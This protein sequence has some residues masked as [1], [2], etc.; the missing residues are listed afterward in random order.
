MLIVQTIILFNIYLFGRMYGR[1]IENTI[2]LLFNIFK[3]Y[4]IALATIAKETGN[5][6]L[7]IY[8]VILQYIW[9]FTAVKNSLKRKIM[10]NFFWTVEKLDENKYKLTHYINDE[11]IHIVIKPNKNYKNIIGIYDEFYN[12]C[13]TDEVK[14]YFLY[15]QSELCSKDINETEN[16]VVVYDKQNE[17]DDEYPTV[18]IPFLSKEVV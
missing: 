6:K 3:N 5:W 1:K 9:F 17:D 12:K 11:K 13:F 2:V 16:L 4:I 8:C 18:T 7:P 10:R 14:P 15:V